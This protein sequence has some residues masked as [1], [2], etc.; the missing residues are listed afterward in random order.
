MRWVLFALPLA[1]LGASG[2]GKAVA[3]DLAARPFAPPV[4]FFTW[5]GFYE[6]LF[7]GYG[8]LDNMTRPVCSVGG[9][10]N[11][12]PCAVRAGLHPPTDDFIAGSELGYNYQ[13]SPGQGL[14]IGVA[15]DAVF[16]RLRG[17]ASE[18]GPF[19]AIQG[20][21]Y[22]L[23]IYHVG[24]RL[25]GLGS[26]RGKVGYAFD[27]VFVYG[28]AG[29]AAGNVRIDT[30]TVLGRTPFEAR[31]G[32][33][34]IG[35]IAGA[36]I[37]YAF[38]QRLSAKVEALYYDLG[39]RT[40][41]AGNIFGTGAARYGSRVDTSGY[42][43]RIGINDR[44]GDGLPVLGLID[45]LRN[46]APDEPAAPS[47]WVFESGARYFYSSGTHRFTLGSAIIPG[48]VNSRLTYDGFGAHSGESFG[49]LDH[50]PTGLFLKGFLGS[51]F[52][53]SGRLR[54]EDFPPVVRG[55]SD[56]LSQI[57][58]GD[59]AYA[60][61]DAGYN[62]LR[63]DTYRLGAFVGFQYFSENVSGY[64]CQQTTAS[65][66]CGNTVPTSVK[67]FTEDA[68]WYALRVGLAGEMRFDRFRFTLEGAY[69]P[70]V[71]LSGEDHHWLRPAINPQPQRGF[72]D[73][74]FFE[75]V[76]SYDLTSRLSVGVGARYWKM[77]APS[78][79]AQFPTLP[80]SPTRFETDR[81]GGFA[82]FSYKIADL[83][84]TPLIAK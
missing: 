76:V 62:I 58:H 74:Y 18:T 16:T 20:G 36:G 44:F 10:P 23:G 24:Q 9:V 64:G 6:G 26:L 4:P 46:P 81:Y 72:G 5:T 77:S 29:A 27:R 30:N 70:A 12:G 41:A 49:R 63:Q 51:G 37:E 2:A 48:Q 68:H 34:R 50:N 60:A 65:T 55:Y 32:E 11:A 52:V 84:L 33:V 82:Q 61:I 67:V 45:E 22:P 66:I 3:A 83:G 38:S 73:G 14:V 79:R 1:A 15:G 21:S 28:T 47:T 39:S 13:F 53:D 80:A 43:V 78:G 25:D 59:I 71:E 19:P 56:T 42:Q 31:H 7:T 17:Y 69:L 40:V 57:R 75:G 35:Y 54:D 8:N